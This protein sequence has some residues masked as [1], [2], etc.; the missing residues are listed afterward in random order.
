MIDKRI[1]D[2]HTVSLPLSLARHR[3]SLYLSLS[4]YLPQLLQLSSIP[5]SSYSFINIQYLSDTESHLS[6]SFPY[7]TPTF[8]YQS[9]I[10][11]FSSLPS[12]LLPLTTLHSPISTFHSPLSSLHSHLVTKSSTRTPMYPSSLPIMRGGLPT[13]A[14]PAFAPATIPC[15]AASSYPETKQIKTG[16][17]YLNIC[18]ATVSKGDI[19]LTGTI[20]IFSCITAQH[21]TAQHSTVPHSSA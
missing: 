14:R 9:A 11:P 5:S 19:I 4:I 20:R 12:P 1:A 7:P 3:F 16:Y 8:P 10:S 13:A 18:K 2:H 17:K 6:L 15:A 21:S